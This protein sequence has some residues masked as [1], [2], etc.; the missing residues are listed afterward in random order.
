MRTFGQHLFA[1]LRIS[2]VPVV[3]AEFEDESGGAFQIEAGYASTNT[4]S[5]VCWAG[6]DGCLIGVFQT[7]GLT[8]FFSREIN[9]KEATPSV[10]FGATRMEPHV[11]F[12]GLLLR[13]RHAAAVLS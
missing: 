10:L 2:T 6:G 3:R 12:H 4:K 8:S 13:S 11:S 7:I 9:R 5:N 1:P